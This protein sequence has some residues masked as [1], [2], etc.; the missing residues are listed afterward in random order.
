MDTT[1]LD[2]TWRTFV[3]TVLDGGELT[4]VINWDT[5]NTQHA[6]LWSKLSGRAVETWLVTYPDTGATTIGFDGPI[7]GFDIGTSQV[8]N[9]VKVTL[10]IKVSGAITVTP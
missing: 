7:T 4:F 5:A 10:K 2:A 1:D 3:A 8:D 6:A 9:N